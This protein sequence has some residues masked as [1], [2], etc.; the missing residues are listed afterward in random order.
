[1]YPFFK[2]LADIVSS[3]LVL[4]FFSP[5]LL[6]ISL[7]SVIVYRESPVFVQ[8]RPGLR[9]KPFRLF[10]L[11]S[12]KSPSGTD[13]SADAGEQ[14]VTQIG[15]LL[16]RSKLDELL[17]FWNVLKGDMSVVGPRPLL[18]EYLPLYI[19]YQMKR[20]EVRTGITGWAQIHGASGLAWTERFE[21]DI[22]YIKNRSI[23]IDLK[24]LFMTCSWFVAVGWK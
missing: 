18:M 16:R 11:K 3:I 20:H 1:M 22:W 8:E 7:L 12:M 17:Q 10:K 19:D 21:K 13:R 4:A 23:H 15:A 14:R 24:I 6:M 2:R 5:I 9:G